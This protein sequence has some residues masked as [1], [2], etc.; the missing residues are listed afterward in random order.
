MGVQ[1]AVG[2]GQAGDM[3]HTSEHHHDAMLLE[4]QVI[5]AQRELAEVDDAAI[6]HQKDHIVLTQ[7]AILQVEVSE[8]VLQIAQQYMQL[9]FQVAVGEVEA[10]HVAQLAESGIQSGRHL[11]VDVAVNAVREAKGDE[12]S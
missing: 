7:P 3:R 11:L 12:E 8:V 2:Q 5:A 4:A 1:L 9:I 10:L 6:V